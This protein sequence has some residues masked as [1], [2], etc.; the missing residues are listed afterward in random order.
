MEFFRTEQN[1]QNEWVEDHDQVVKLKCDFVISA[2][3]S[4]LTEDTVRRAMEPVRF[5][6]WGLPDVDAITMSTSE[7]WVFAGL[8]MIKSSSAAAILFSLKFNL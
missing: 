7:P 5:N 8:K 4:T 1:E 3:G 2:F 6:K